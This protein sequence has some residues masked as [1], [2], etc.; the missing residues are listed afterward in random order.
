MYQ[1]V[2]VTGNESM[3]ETRITPV[4]V[5]QFIP[6]LS[7]APL[8]LLFRLQW[9]IH[10]T[11]QCPLHNQH[12]GYGL[13]LLTRTSYHPH[14]IILISIWNRSLY[15]LNSYV[16]VH[17]SYTTYSD[18]EAICLYKG[19]SWWSVQLKINKRKPRSLNKEFNR[20]KFSALFYTLYYVK[21]LRYTSTI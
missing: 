15:P 2:R 18:R 16:D 3:T 7:K 20:G 17:P 8:D 12:D 19:L 1:P 6:P 5:V 4:W 21:I 9:C 13:F 10:E 14:R 11:G